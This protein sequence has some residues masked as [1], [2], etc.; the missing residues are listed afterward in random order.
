[1][2]AYWMTSILEITVEE[3]SVENYSNSSHWQ[4]HVNLLLPTQHTWKGGLPL[5]N[6]WVTA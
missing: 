5:A 6:P 4:L 1:M 3:C 2:W